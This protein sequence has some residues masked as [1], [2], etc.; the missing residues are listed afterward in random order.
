MIDKNT[1]KEIR[2]F[3]KKAKTLPV[4]H[5]NG[6][7]Y[8]FAEKQKLLINADNTN[9]FIEL[10]NEEAKEY[11]VN[12]EE[13]ILGKYDEYREIANSIIDQIS[14]VIEEQ[15]GLNPKTLSKGDEIDGPALLNGEVYYALEDEI[16]EKLK[17][18]VLKRNIKIAHKYF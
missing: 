8:Y 14:E 3:F 4:I 12:L 11:K 1:W 2:P 13:G 7:R 15:Y 17:E 18:F 9:V 5:I 16:S 10:T 6:K